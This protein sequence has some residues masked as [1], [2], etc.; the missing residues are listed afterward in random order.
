MKSVNDIYA[1]LEET[2]SVI[3]PVSPEHPAPDRKAVI[4]VI[5]NLHT[6]LFPGYFFSEAARKEGL[7]GPELLNRIRETLTV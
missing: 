6:L 5:K 3:H 2:K 1:A 7:S 4:D